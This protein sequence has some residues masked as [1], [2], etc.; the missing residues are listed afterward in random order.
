MTELRYFL[1]YEAMKAYFMSINYYSGNK[2][3]P[4]MAVVKLLV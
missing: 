4:I 2:I 3:I 1:L